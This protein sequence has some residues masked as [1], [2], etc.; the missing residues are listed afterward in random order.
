MFD[1]YLS[2]G[3]VEVLNRARVATYLKAFLPQ[4]EVLCSTTGMNAA[5]GHSTY[6]TPALNAAP[7]YKS[8]QASTADFYG[9]FPGKMEGAEDST[10][11][12]QVTELSSHGAV[13]TSPRHAST[14]I[15]FVAT[16]FAKN[17][18]AMMAGIAWLRQVLANEGCSDQD[19]GCTGRT[20][21]VFSAMPTTTANA[22]TFGRFF[23]KSEITEGPLV[24]KKFNTKGFLMWQIDFT[25]T[26]GVPWPFSSTS[27]IGTLDMNSATNFQ[28]PAGENCSTVNSAYDDFISDPYFTGISRP[29][30]PP[31]ILPPNI[32][33]IS[34]WRRKTLTLPAITQRWGRIAPVISVLTEGAAAKYLR[35]RFYRSAAGVSGCDFDGEFIISYM[36]A[37]S[38]LTLNSI[39]REAT[40]R[41]NGGRT[42]PAGHLLFGSDGRPFLWPSLGCHSTYTMTA[43]L[44]PGH[45]GVAVV[46]DTA[47]RE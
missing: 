20:A 18:E 14:E 8:T 25:L 28:D 39:T 21:K 26:S 36:P 40:M 45:T 30:R 19:I 1:G 17:E 31:V 4:V 3:G 37:N 12:L 10:R 43:D 44:M 13:L 47:V 33:E 7:W 15:R 6:T 2:I 16:A 35:L 41:V 34:S 38:V 9:L 5:L 27:N 42:V 22:A 23:Y 11:E 32:L 46:L 29:P 24:T